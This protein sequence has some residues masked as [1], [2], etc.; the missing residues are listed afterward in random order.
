MKSTNGLSGEVE[1]Q[2]E[3][4]KEQVPISLQQIRF[5]CLLKI[6]LENHGKFFVHVRSLSLGEFSL[7]LTNRI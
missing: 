5:S 1:Q 7:F 6:V 3:N 2:T 4:L